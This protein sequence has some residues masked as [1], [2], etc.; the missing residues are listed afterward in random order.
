MWQ[1]PWTLQIWTFPG[2]SQKK[3]SWGGKCHSHVQSLCKRIPHWKG[4]RAEIGIIIHHNPIC[5]SWPRSMSFMSTTQSWVRSMHVKSVM[6]LSMTEANWSST[7]WSTQPSSHLCVSSV[8]K[9]L[10]G[11]QA[12]RWNQKYSVIFA[13]TY[14]FI[15]NK[16]RHLSMTSHCKVLI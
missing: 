4:K 10:I 2:D 13:F 15:P 8:E 14:H 5:F 3:S 7:H 11:L 1:V 12:F 16:L 6:P 9:D